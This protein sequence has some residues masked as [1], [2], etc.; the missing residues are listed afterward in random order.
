MK[1]LKKEF[2]IKTSKIGQDT[3]DE[4]ELKILNR[5]VRYTDH[6]IELEA[7]LRHAELIVSQLGLTE[8][9]ELT[10]PAAEEVKRDDDEDP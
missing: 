3:K 5:I 10:C 7:D 2:K 9:K 6:G 4:K 8:S 1:R